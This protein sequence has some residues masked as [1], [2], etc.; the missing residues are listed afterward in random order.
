MQLHFL[1]PDKTVC[2]TDLFGCEKIIP[3]GEKKIVEIPGVDK[4]VETN[5]YNMEEFIRGVYNGLGLIP[6]DIQFDC[7]GVEQVFDIVQRFDGD[8]SVNDSNGFYSLL[9]K[10]KALALI[11]D[12]IRDHLCPLIQDKRAVYAFDLACSRIRSL[13]G[14]E[15]PVELAEHFIESLL[16]FSRDARL[17]M[18]FE[19]NVK[20]MYINA[21]SKC[22]S[23]DNVSLVDIAGKAKDY[24]GRAN[25]NNS[26]TVEKSIAQYREFVSKHPIE[27]RLKIDWTLYQ[28]RC[29]INFLVDFVLDLIA[30]DE[31]D[32][33]H[34]ITSC[35]NQFVKAQAKFSEAVSSG[36]LCELRQFM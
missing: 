9:M 4:P 35:I 18:N 15:D 14:G 30:L 3:T 21:T 23:P 29:N 32:D 8:N 34:E 6:S 16:P 22:G 12:F 2:Q 26:N 19:R 20:H 10:K 17:N 31:E 13:S 5:N 33:M 7:N 27:K 1:D 11:E 28:K 36:K 24:L 25:V